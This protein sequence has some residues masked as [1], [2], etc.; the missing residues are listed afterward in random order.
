VSKVAMLDAPGAVMIGTACAML[1]V[2]VT[3]AITQ[4]RNIKAARQ[5]HYT[6]RPGFV[7]SA[8]QSVGRVVHRVPAR[9]RIGLALGTL[10]FALSA[11]ATSAPLLVP[12]T[13]GP[14]GRALWLA[15]KWA[16]LGAAMQGVRKWGLLRRGEA[17]LD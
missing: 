6:P 10:Y 3:L 13:E 7:R 15:S 16:V 4:A 2:R 5:Q 9:M 12:A 8:M 17:R 14:V 1:F 11:L